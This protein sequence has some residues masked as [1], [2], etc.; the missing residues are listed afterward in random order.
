MTL[1]VHAVAVTIWSDLDLLIQLLEWSITVT[2]A[3]LFAELSAWHGVR[4]M[5]FHLTGARDELHLKPLS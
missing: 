2:K 1:P 5:L 3:R 4:F